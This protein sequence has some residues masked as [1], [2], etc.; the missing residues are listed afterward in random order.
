MW[1]DLRLGSPSGSPQGKPSVVTSN[2]SGGGGRDMASPSPPQEATRT[3]DG[4]TTTTSRT[5]ASADAAEYMEPH[6][7]DPS[8]QS[9]LMEVLDDTETST[10]LWEPCAVAATTATA[11]AA[12]AITTTTTPII[13]NVSSNNNRVSNISKPMSMDERRERR[14]QQQQQQTPSPQPAVPGQSQPRQKNAPSPQIVKPP[15]T[16]EKGPVPPS[17]PMRSPRVP[18]PTKTRQGYLPANTT[19]GLDDR[20]TSLPTEANNNTNAETAV[21]IA[22]LSSQLITHQKETLRALQELS[23]TMTHLT[24]VQMKRDKES[25]DED[26]DQLNIDR[27]TVRLDGLEVYAV[28]SAL[29]VATAIACFDVYATEHVVIGDRLNGNDLLHLTL[30]TVFLAVSGVGIIAGLHATLVFSLMTM[31]GRT[32]VGVSHDEA[33]V[34][35]FVQTGRVRYRGFLTFRMSL[36]CFLIQVVFT[37]TSKATP[38]LRP[39]IVLANLTCM[40]WVYHDTQSVIDKAGDILFS[41]TPK[42]AK[43]MSLRRTLSNGSMKKDKSN[44]RSTPGLAGMAARARKDTSEKDRD[45]DDDD[46]DDDD[47]SHDNPNHHNTKPSPSRHTRTKGTP[48]RSKSGVVVYD[49]SPGESRPARRGKRKPGK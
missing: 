33:F 25:H 37:I 42:A 6:M 44:K 5:T 7:L 23:Q 17:S 14:Q 15:P 13:V 21:L 4:N 1:S 3:R 32:A 26:D 40:Y 28:V 22:D 2:G 18:P 35:F 48:A 30:N 12:P 19:N 24:M 46:D 16:Y 41:Q 11:A 45:S 31:Y 29:T 43:D 10:N 47:S 8:E 38:A 9:E 27:A 36:Y 49:V 20:E 34:E 39:L